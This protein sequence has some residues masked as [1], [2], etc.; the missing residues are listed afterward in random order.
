MELGKEF[1]AA[2]NALLNGTSGLL[3]VA[4]YVRILRRR[5]RA[6]AW[7]MVAASQVELA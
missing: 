2:V 7:L 6:H 3:L 5:V 4:G 1:F